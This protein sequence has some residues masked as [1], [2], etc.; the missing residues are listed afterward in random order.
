MK[1]FDQMHLGMAQVLYDVETSKIN[2]V[3]TEVSYSM[4]LKHFFWLVYI[5]VSKYGWLSLG[6][7]NK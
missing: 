7:I 2:I 5:L 4:G 1:I 6:Q 3:K